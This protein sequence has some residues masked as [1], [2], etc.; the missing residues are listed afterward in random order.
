MTEEEREKLRKTA[1]D[2][3]TILATRSKSHAI[4]LETA[5]ELLNHTSAKPVMRTRYMGGSTSSS[6]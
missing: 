4:R 3:L 6:A 1:F 5:V 2:T